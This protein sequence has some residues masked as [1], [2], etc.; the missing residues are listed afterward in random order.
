MKKLLLVFATCFLFSCATDNKKKDIEKSDPMSGIMVGKDSKSDAMLQFTK[1]YQENN[2]SSAKSI[3]TEDVVFNV[4]DTKMSFDQVNAGFSSGHD[5]F[6]NIKHTEFNVSTMYYNDGKIFTNYWYT[7]TATSK[8]TNNE[9][10]LK[11]Y[12]WFK[13]ENDKVVEVYN[14]FDPTA[15]NAEMAE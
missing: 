3:F 6:D 2:M 13:W 9:I 8:K 4:N 15:Y 10:T 5:F 7:W 12:S 1:A 11:G 14:A